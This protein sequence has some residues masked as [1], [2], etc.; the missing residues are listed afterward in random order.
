MPWRETYRDRDIQT[1]TQ[2]ERET[3]REIERK[4]ERERETTAGS[5]I[6]RHDNMRL[7]VYDA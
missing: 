2:R 7:T 6:F 4:R 5:V 1:D 3:V